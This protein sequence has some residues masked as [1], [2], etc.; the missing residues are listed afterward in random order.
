VSLVATAAGAG[1]RVPRIVRSAAG[2]V[3]AS[4]GAG[5]WRVFE[6]VDI[7]GTPSASDAGSALALLHGVSWA[8][9]EPVDPWFTRR[10][11]GGPWHELARAA[12][13]QPWGPL[14]R[15]H[16]P[17]LAALDAVAEDDSLP[18]CVVCHRDFHESNVVLDRRRRVVVLDWDNCGPLPPEREVGY[19]L[20]ALRNLNEATEFLSGYRHAGG[21][22][23]PRGMG[24]FAT[25]AAVWGNYLGLCVTRALAGDARAAGLAE[26]MLQTPLTV[27]HLGHLLG[28]ATRATFEPPAGCR[29]T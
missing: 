29:R 20:G 19:A 16:L 1:V 17:D 10:T 8:S 7:S 6:W 18:P 25:A 21:V 24:A 12:R 2:T 22:F 3:V 4:V 11:E 26:S 14:L 23:E 13:G 9:R 5:I 28:A 27:E 15:R